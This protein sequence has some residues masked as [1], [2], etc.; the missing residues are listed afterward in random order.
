MFVYCVIDVCFVSVVRLSFLVLGVVCFF[1]LWVDGCVGVWVLVYVA[2]GLGLELWL[3]ACGLWVWRLDVALLVVGCRVRGSGL[4]LFGCC[5]VV[6]AV[7]CII[8]VFGVLLCFVVFC[9][10]VCM[11]CFGWLGW[12][13]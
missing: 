13:C 2:G 9:V 4:G 7:Y 11:I 5:C 6:V 3:V 8:G 1:S 10:F 12:C